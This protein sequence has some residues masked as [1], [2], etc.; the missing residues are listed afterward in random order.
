[1]HFGI[2]LISFAS[3]VLTAA[4]IAGLQG[5]EAVRDRPVSR[6]LR[7]LVWAALA[8]SYV[9][10]YLG[11]Y[12]RHSGA[13]L[14]CLDWPLCNSA[15]VPGFAGPIGVQVI[16]R[17]AAGVL[18]LLLLGLWLQARR[19][20]AVRPD[21]YRAGTAAFALVL[22]QALSGG[23]VVLSRLELFTLLLHAALV[24]LLFASLCYM[25]YQLIPQ[26]LCLPRRAPSAPADAVGTSAKQEA[27][28]H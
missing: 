28:S 6:R 20:R 19:A 16:H 24:A 5:G 2:S 18:V 21:L 9:V 10:V 27:I 13:S 22:V 11:A 25:A 26:R 4:F 23:L 1:L 3:V 15:L 12:V 17:F 14:A 7:R 8:Y